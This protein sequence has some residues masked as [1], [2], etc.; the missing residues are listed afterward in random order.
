MRFLEKY[1]FRAHARAAIR[2]SRAAK[3]SNIFPFQKAIPVKG[4][5]EM[6]MSSRE[7]LVISEEANFKMLFFL[8]VF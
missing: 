8:L 2:P 3:F 4:A 5:I 6:G 7:S 1:D